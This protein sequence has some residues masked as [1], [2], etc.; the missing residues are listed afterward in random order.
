MITCPWCGTSYLN[1]KPNC[2]NCGGPLPLPSMLNQPNDAP[3]LPPPPAAPRPISDRYVWK[4]VTVDGWAI[5]G[6]VLGLI[7]VIFLFLGLALILGLITAFVGIPFAILGLGLSVSGFALMFWRYMEKQKIVNVL[8]W[9]NAAQGVINTVEQNY[10]VRINQRH[11]WR[12]EYQFQCGQQT[13][14]G[15]VSTLDQPGP[16]FLPGRP[17][18]VLYM[19][20]EPQLNALYPHP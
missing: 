13:L 1:F 19:P 4:L 10:A 12:I 15:Q 6:F 17:V 3:I 8:R 16:Q 2:A 14:T 20:G 5:A 7:G 18:F 9:G 11:P